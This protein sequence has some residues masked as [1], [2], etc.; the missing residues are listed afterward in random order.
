[1]ERVEKSRH[2]WR[3]LNHLE[4]YIIQIEPPGTL[5]ARL[6]IKFR[7]WQLRNF[8]LGTFYRMTKCFDLCI[9]SI[10]NEC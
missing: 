3:H 7:L 10:E 8:A 5:R 1:M 9:A 6:R 4:C 2:R